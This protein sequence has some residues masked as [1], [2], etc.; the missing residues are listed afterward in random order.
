MPNS[1]TMPKRSLFYDMRPV[2]SL[3]WKAKAV[4]ST[5]SLD[6]IILKHL[7]VAFLLANPEFETFSPGRVCNCY[8]MIK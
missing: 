4:T 5:E 7:R 8:F 3:L 2:T 1:A 6:R